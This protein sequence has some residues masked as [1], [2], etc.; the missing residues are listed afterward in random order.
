MGVNIRGQGEVPSRLRALNDPLAPGEGRGRQ[1][2]V[3]TW[4]TLLA[5]TNGE[6]NP[7]R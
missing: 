2:E 6:V 1:G 3:V 7:R 4:P 5:L